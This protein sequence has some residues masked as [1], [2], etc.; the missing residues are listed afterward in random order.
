MNSVA[1]VERLDVLLG[2]PVVGRCLQHLRMV[3]YA[4]TMSIH[5]RVHKVIPSGATLYGD[6]AWMKC[7]W[8][9]RASWM[10]SKEYRLG[11]F[12]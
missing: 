7:E 3:L 5:F 1:K 6:T 4:Y 10:R 9:R 11:T 8:K 12:P 2:V